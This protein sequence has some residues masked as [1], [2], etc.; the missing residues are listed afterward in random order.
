MDSS[1]LFVG[2]M[3]KKIKKKP[4][5]TKKTASKKNNID[6]SG[7]H[8]KKIG[9]LAQG[10]RMCVKGQKLVLF[11]TGLCPRKC[12]YCPIS[13]KKSQHDV[14]YANEW[15]TKD[16]TDIIH[17]A[18][19]CNAKGAGFTGGDPLVKIH[20]TCTYIRKL[21]AEFGK[22]FHI[23]L[24]TSFDLVSPEKLKML[25]DAGLDEIR[26]HADLDDD[27]LWKRILIANMFSWDVGVEIPVMPG[28]KQKTEKLLKFLDKRIKFLNLNELEVS[29]AVANKLSEQG[30]RTKDSLSYGV[31][32]S[33]KLA[34]E[35]MQFILKN[36]F[37]YTVHYCTAKLKDSVQLA[38]RIK[39]RA[40][41]MKKPYDIL[42]KNGMLTRG[43]IYLPFLLPSVG[44]E[45]KLNSLT[46][47]QRN[48]V[49]RKLR[50]FRNY[51]M[52]EHGVPAK[53]LDIDEHRMRLLTNVV[54]VTELE[55]DIKRASL[56]PCIVTEYP[57]W[58]AMI[59]ELDWI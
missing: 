32:G 1:S 18:K 50:T 15:P 47:E 3:K 31:K 59:V 38:E 58:D 29:D 11:V 27:S 40:K 24:Y 55:K 53:L 30:F 36:K 46:K 9:A 44:Y 35:L 54:V 21:K 41:S 12:I 43:A 22:N 7:F 34:K 6:D 23:H 52:R 8:S 14:T 16:I 49:L 33:E 19:L 45:K 2:I 25:H 42:E 5:K 37:S 28:K 51:I 56:K 57:T 17:E 4:A 26:F 39:R 48:V 10:C 20:R 13:D